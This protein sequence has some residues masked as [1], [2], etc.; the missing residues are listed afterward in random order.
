MENIVIIGLV[1]YAICLFAKNLHK[2]YTTGSY[3]EI[4]S[5]KRMRQY[6]GERAEIT[7]RYYR[8]EIDATLNRTHGEWRNSESY[9][10]RHRELAQ[11]D[12]KYAV[13]GSKSHK[14]IREKERSYR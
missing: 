1:V 7:G 14:E 10:A 9:R 2:S 8:G 6:L 13:P 3:K 4:H 5:A 12:E 11:L